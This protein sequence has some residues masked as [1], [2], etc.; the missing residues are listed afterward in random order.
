M[1]GYAGANSGTAAPGTDSGAGT[2]LRGDAV[3]TTRRAP[4]AVAWGYL[5]PL[6]SL[7]VVLGPTGLPRSVRDAGSW[8]VAM[9]RCWLPG[10]QL[11]F[12]QDNHARYFATYYTTRWQGQ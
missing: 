3:M 8:T 1:I 2:A 5:S 4:P 11:R 7:L 9:G 12:G 10:T 6:L